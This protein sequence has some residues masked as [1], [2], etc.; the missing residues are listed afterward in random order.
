MPFQTGGA[1]E[2]VN[3]LFFQCARI[4]MCL[5]GGIGCVM[6]C[7]VWGCPT[8]VY[9]YGQINLCARTLLLGVHTY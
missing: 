7:D 5:L 3:S 2:R 9:A 6:R 8:S 4:L 1:S